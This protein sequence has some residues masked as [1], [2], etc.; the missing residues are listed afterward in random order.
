MNPGKEKLKIKIEKSEKPLTMDQVL[1]LMWVVML[2]I[3][4]CTMVI[5]RFMTCVLLGAGV[6]A[7]VN[8]A[9]GKAPGKKP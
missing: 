1:I 9:V 2:P 5:G 8:K 7:Y 4:I 6:F 3:I